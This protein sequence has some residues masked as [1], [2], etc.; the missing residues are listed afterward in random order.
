MENPLR[1]K[2]AEQCHAQWVHWMKYLFTR[3]VFHKDGSFTINATSTDRWL[4]Q[5][6]CYYHE[7][8]EQEKDSDRKEADKFLR[9]VNDELKSMNEPQL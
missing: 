7:L 4:T 2:L 5:N 1:E 3:G 9:I 8:S 6:A